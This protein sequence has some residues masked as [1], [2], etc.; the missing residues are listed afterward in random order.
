VGGSARASW[1]T[2]DRR[3]PAH[4]ALALGRPLLIP[5]RAG[6]T[7]EHVL[8]RLRLALARPAELPQTGSSSARTT[9]PR[10]PSRWRRGRCCSS[11]TC[12]TFDLER[13]AYVLEYLSRHV[14][15][16]RIFVTSRIEVTPPPA[17]EHMNDVARAAGLDTRVIARRP[18]ARAAQ[19]VSS[20]SSA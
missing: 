2:S 13:T 9:W 20:S 16:S 10:S 11:T 4:A 14:R 17:T 1:S 19:R 7:V 8:A 18:D 15:E 3:G 12:I 5:V 6:L